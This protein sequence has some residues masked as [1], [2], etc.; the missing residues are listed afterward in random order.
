MP[1]GVCVLLPA[2]GKFAPQEQSE[3]SQEGNLVIEP[4]SP[5]RQPT[6]NPLAAEFQQNPFPTLR[7]LRDYDP[8]HLTR[9]GWVVTR[10]DDCAA[11][12]ASRDFGMRG[13]EDLVRKQVG[14]GPALEFIANRFHS[15]DPPEHTRLRSLVGQAFSAPRI[16][17]MRV[18]IEALAEHLLD[19]VRTNTPFDLIEAFA[20]PLPSW[21]IA[22]MLGTPMEDRVHLSTWTER[23]L[24]LQG[25]PVPDNVTRQEG[26]AAA[27]DFMAYTRQLIDVRRK[28]PGNDVLSALIAAEEQ[29]ERLTTEE[30]AECVVF[31]S[32]AGFTTTRNLIGSAVVA[33][34]K[35][36]DQWELLV[37]DPSLVREAVE[38]ALRYDCSLTSTPRFARHE[39]IVG[40]RRL[41]G[42]AAVSCLLNAANRDPQ[43]F[44]DPDRF[45]V[46]R[47]DKKHLAFGG[48][49]H[50]CLGA[51]L[52]RLQIEIALS[53]LVRRYP[54][55]RLATERIE[56][57]SG[58]YRGPL[59]VP[60]SAT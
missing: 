39:T 36:R 27:R 9:L 28:Q 50:F 11:V 31:L 8:V 35:N 46:L 10:Y 17:A 13:L 51:P 42:G 7:N 45:D 22:E 26:H 40:G 16:Q 30:I 3:E 18:H 14:P 55:L 24:K 5:R 44:A 58:L 4:P 34:L 53:A 12:L 37:E 41:A 38:E 47:T 57:R 54:R 49:V 56:W 59:R 48:G 33:L 52:A 6:Y 23:I 29:G 60:V 2:I 32:N 25:M 1:S 20:H 15:F 43:R 19:E 21:V